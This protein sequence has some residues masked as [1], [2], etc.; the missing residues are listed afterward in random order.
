M[1]GQA[2]LYDDTADLLRRACRA[3]AADLATLDADKGNVAAY[4][5][6]GVDP[7]AIAYVIGGSRL[8]SQVLKRRWSQ[9]DC[10]KVKGANAYF[11]MPNEALYWQ[12]VC[13]D[14]AKLAPGDP[15]TDRIVGDTKTIFEMFAKTFHHT[16]QPTLSEERV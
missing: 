12:S 4:L 14:L 16:M 3:L 1:A 8:G 7:L 11:S 10:P 13:K 2:G 15:R 6:D 9:S 5:P